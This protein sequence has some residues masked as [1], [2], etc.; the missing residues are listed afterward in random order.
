MD[1]YALFNRGSLM[2]PRSSRAFLFEK[3]IPPFQRHG[4]S[5]V[6]VN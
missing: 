5:I 1:V 2:H 6:V 4:S 3:S